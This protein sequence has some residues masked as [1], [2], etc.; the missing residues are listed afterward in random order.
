[1]TLCRCKGI[2]AR[3]QSGL[4]MHPG[5]KNLHDWCEVYFEGCGWVPVDQS[6]GVTPYGGYFFLGGIEPYRLVVNNDFSRE[7]SPAKKYPRSDTV[8]F[9]RGEVEWEGGNLY[10]NQWSYHFEIEYL[11]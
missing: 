1:M 6:F 8:D 10:Y 11:D 7:F 4:M 9:Q 3:W 5:S 2:P